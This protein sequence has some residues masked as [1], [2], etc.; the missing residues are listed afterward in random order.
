[1]TS[2]TFGTIAARTGHLI[3][4]PAAHS[5][6]ILNPQGTQVYDLW[7]FS[8][9]D[10]LNSKSKADPPS[11]HAPA[12]HDLSYLSTSHTRVQLKSTTIHLNDTLYSNKRR[13]LLQLVEDT[14]PGVHDTLF[15]CCDPARYAMLLGPEDDG[16]HASCLG[17]LLTA[18][19]DSDAFSELAQSQNQSQGQSHSY[20]TQ[21]LL[22]GEW[23]PDPVNLFMNVPHEALAG[24][25][26]GKGND[27]KM[28]LERGVCQAGGYVVLRNVSEGELSCVLSCCPM[29]LNEINGEVLGGA[30]WEVI[31]D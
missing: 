3:T 2:P 29:D 24:G 27:G 12:Q 1:M 25:R 14:S 15:S 23:W 19:R 18:V 16:N 26:D 4:L 11:V 5:L 20:L 10:S 8:R 17:N 22:A 9:S 13:P 21:A 7:A 28:R 6:K 30:E 31:S